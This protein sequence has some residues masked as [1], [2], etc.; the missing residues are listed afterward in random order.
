VSS[1]GTEGNGFS[2]HP[3]LSQ[4]GRDVAFIS[5][6]SNLV[7]GDTNAAVDVFVHDN[8]DGTTDRVS[9]ATSGT[10]SN[11]ISDQPA[12]S[13]DGL[14]VAFRSRAT[15]LV[16]GD[17]NGLDD[18]FVRD[19]ATG[20]T[21]RITTSGGSEPSISGSGRY[22]VYANGG[23]VY[24]YDRQTQ[25]TERMDSAAAG[26]NAVSPDVSD[27]GRFVVF[28]TYPKVGVYPLE[29]YLHDRQTGDITAIPHEF[30]YACCPVISGDGTVAVFQVLVPVNGGVGTALWA[31]D[32]GAGSG[33]WVTVTS[34]G[35]V[36]TGQVFSYAVSD[37]GRFVSFTT[38]DALVPEDGNSQVDDYVRDREQARTILAG[39]NA[40]GGLPNAGVY[41]TSLSGD[42]R[43]LAFG[44]PASNIVGNDKNNTYDIFVRAFPEPIPQ[45]VTPSVVARGTDTTLTVTGAYLEP[46]SQVS[47]TGAGVQ[48][49]GVTWISESTLQVHVHV[50]PDAATGARSVIIT[51]TGTGPGPNAGA[52][53]VCARCLS[54]S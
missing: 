24:L 39:R 42:G 13:D 34:T 50:D 12:I 32:L 16:A 31:A 21:E 45:S 11:E 7:T 47:V 52:S 28:H 15:N 2:D 23:G 53:G 22:V 35:D 36:A 46:S 40:N 5:G 27:D 4:D 6:S 8:R 19:R 10:Q 29:V 26:T 3:A 9:V 43:Y 54:I 41:T 18:V 1:N 49:N 38:G 25:L 37:D 14:V 17:T 20:T 48:V 44:T 30:A 51:V 33:D